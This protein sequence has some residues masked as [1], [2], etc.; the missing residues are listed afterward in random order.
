[1]GGSINK[2]SL[3]DIDIDFNN[4]FKYFITERYNIFKKKSIGLEAP[5]TS[6]ITLQKYRFTNIFRDDDKV[7]IFI[8]DWMKDIKELKFLIA[9]LIYARLCNKPETMLI[10][11]LIDTNFDPL[12]FIE[13]IDKIGGGKTASKV[14]VNSVWRG[15]Y[16]VSGTF[17]KLGYPYREHLIAHHILKTIDDI[18]QVITNNRF[19]DISLYLIELNKIWGY[20]C[21]IVFTQVLLD[22]SYLKPEIITPDIS[23]PL[24]SGVEPLIQAM[25]TPYNTLIDLAIELWANHDGRTMYPKDAEHAL[26]VFRKYLCWKHGTSNPR[27]YKPSK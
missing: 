17:K 8:Y 1:M 4:D 6:D 26:C 27:H 9:N 20:N 7:S 25:N 15:P 14:N 11:G 3:K 2:N 22:L 19:S 10:T 24:S 23:V 13:K 18:T 16:Q 21:N 5:W 12:D